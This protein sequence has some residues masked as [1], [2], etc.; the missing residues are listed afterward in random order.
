MTSGFLE[1]GYGALGVSLCTSIVSLNDFQCNFS[2]YVN[3]H[4]QGFRV[5]AIKYVSLPDADADADEESRRINTAYIIPTTKFCL[6]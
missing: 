2:S 5:Y 1:W 4:D 6:G 3:I